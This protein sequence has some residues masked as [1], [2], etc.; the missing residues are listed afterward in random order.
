[1]PRKPV[2]R[3]VVYSPPGAPPRSATLVSPRPDHLDTI[4]V[5]VHPGNGS[6][7]S[8]KQLKGWQDFY[9]AHGIPS[10]AIDYFLVTP[11]APP[12]IYPEP[13]R[14]AK[15]AVQWVR[16]NAAELG[17]DPARV[18]VE[19]FT[20]G[21]ALGAQ[22]YVTPGDEFFQGSG[23][24]DGVSDEAA[25][26]IGVAGTYDGT[27]KNLVQYYGGPPE[28]ADPD[29]RARYVQANSVGQAGGAS[30]PA[31]L[32]PGDAAQQAKAFQQALADAGVAVELGAAAD[33]GGQEA[34]ALAWL[35]AQFPPSSP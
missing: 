15:A 10:L 4:V 13:Q 23:L 16:S 27:V 2:R 1:V 22:A 6:N 26:F 12:P 3:N 32:F 20:A 18:V 19:G 24:Y 30:G 7:G 21:A 14:D 5:L 9:A 28:S 25:G 35:T 29:V 31:L 8:R 34:A 17:V 33:Q 11:T